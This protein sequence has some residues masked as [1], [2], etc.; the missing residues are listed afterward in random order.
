MNANAIRRFETLKGILGK[1]YGVAD[2]TRKFAV[3]PTVE[4][5]LQDKIIAT[6][7]FLQKINVVPVTE[8]KGQNIF[9]A[10]SGPVTGRTDT[11][12]DGRERKTRDVLSLTHAEYELFRTNSDVHI[13]YHTIDA[14]A[15]F[16]DLGQRYTGYV[17]KR[18]AVDRELVGWNGEQAAANTDL[19]TYPLMQDVNKGWMQYVRQNLPANVLLQGSTPGEIRIG[20]GGDYANLDLA[21]FDLLQAI[22]AFL[23]DG[24]VALVGSDLIAQESAALFAAVGGKPTEKNAMN[25]A[26]ARLGGL[27]WDSPYNFPARGIVV[28]SYDNL[29]IYYQESS[30]RRQIV[31]EPKKNR[32]EDYNSRNEGYVVETPEKFAALE[33]K[34]VKLPDGSGGWA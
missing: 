5:R 10:A 24:L 28:T 26:M 22:P 29:S 16:P 15:K 12:V 25:M 32:V 14:W 11:T 23:R 2:V 6:S 13:T 4:Q 30:W 33:F 17:Q 9:G 20:A 8:L 27:V 7:D 31:E 19:A 1:A 18:I 34:N 21:V 3:D